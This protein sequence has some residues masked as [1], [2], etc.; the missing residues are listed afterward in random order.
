VL[1]LVEAQLRG[2]TLAK[3]R[4]LFQWLGKSLFLDEGIAQK[5]G[6]ALEGLPR[7]SWVFHE[8]DLLGEKSGDVHGMGIR[9][10]AFPFVQGMVSVNVD[11]RSFAK[12]LGARLSEMV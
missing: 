1:S 4:R 12:A 7:V 9:F 6:L 10:F 11:R 2:F 8:S 3:Q 5:L